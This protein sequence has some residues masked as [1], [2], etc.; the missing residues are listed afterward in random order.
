MQC[1]RCRREN[2]I[3][4]KF[5]GECGTPV[6]EAAPAARSYADLKDEN[7][8]RNAK[9]SNRYRGRRQLAGLGKETH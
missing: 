7:A 2:P 1:P 8:P 6:V 4:Q 3:G 9:R 5:Y